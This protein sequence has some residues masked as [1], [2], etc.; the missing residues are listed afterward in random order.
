MQYTEKTIK[1]S[2]YTVV[3]RRP[4]LTDSEREKREQDVIKALERF[5]KGK[6]YGKV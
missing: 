1:T 6:D 5:G 4:I 2:S 3:I